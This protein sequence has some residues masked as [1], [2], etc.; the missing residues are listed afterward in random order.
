MVVLFVERFRARKEI[1][2]KG[3]RIY[4]F[5]VVDERYLFFMWLGI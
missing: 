3:K 1:T 5:F 2:T 4:L